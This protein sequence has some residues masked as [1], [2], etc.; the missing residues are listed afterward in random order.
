MMMTYEKSLVLLTTVIKEE[1]DK[2]VA[3]KFFFHEKQ[4]SFLNLSDN[5]Y[6]F[7]LILSLLVLFHHRAVKT[8]SIQVPSPI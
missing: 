3:S 6:K 8:N 7:L 2:F 5:F 1:N 4:F